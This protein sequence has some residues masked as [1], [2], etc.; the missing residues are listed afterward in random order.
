MHLNSCFV[1][2]TTK[3]PLLAFISE[4]LCKL[5]DIVS[6][7]LFFTK[8]TTLYCS[9]LQFPSHYYLFVVVENTD[10]IFRS[11]V[12]NLSKYFL[13]MQLHKCKKNNFTNYFIQ[14]CVRKSWM[15]IMKTYIESSDISSSITTYLVNII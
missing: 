15:R 6:D 7:Y 11:V 1:L 12:M 2:K 14:M 10:G 8:K 13:D 9:F 4:I 5:F 3:T